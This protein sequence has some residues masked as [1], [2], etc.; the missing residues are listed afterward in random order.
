MLSNIGLYYP[1]I[2]FQDD[3]WVKLTALYLDKLGRIALPEYTIRD[4]DTVERLKG[5]LDFIKDFKPTDEETEHISDRFLDLLREHGQELKDHY[6]FYYDSDFYECTSEAFASFIN[7]H[8]N[9]PLIE[10]IEELWSHSNQYS[11]PPKPAYIFA[12]GRMDSYLLYELRRW[13]S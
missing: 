12:S 4:S 11:L 7:W 10:E 9:W 13:G 8:Q 3:A 6:G 2:E 5:D 1:F